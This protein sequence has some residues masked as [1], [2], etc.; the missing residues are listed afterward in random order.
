MKFVQLISY[1]GSLLALDEDGKVYGNFAPSFVLENQ[2]IIK[3]ELLESV[4]P[5]VA[6][7]PEEKPPPEP[8]PEEPL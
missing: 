2:K 5:E 1:G 4:M 3:W 8:E 6:E 7:E